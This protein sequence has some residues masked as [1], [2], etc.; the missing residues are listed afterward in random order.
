MAN[1]VVLVIAGEEERYQPSPEFGYVVKLQ[2]DNLMASFLSGEIALLSNMKA[3]RIG[4]R[5]RSRLW[6]IEGGLPFNDNTSGIGTLST[7]GQIQYVAPLFISYSETVA[8][9][10][11]IV[12]KVKANIDIEQ[13]RQV[14]QPLDCVIKKQMEFTTQEYLLDVLGADADAVFY[15]VEEL[16]EIDCVEWAA[17]NIACQGR[18]A[19]DI[20]EQGYASNA[21]QIS[22]ISGFIPNDEYMPMQW[23]LHNTGQFGYTPD[24]DI[25]ALEAWEITAGDPNIVIAI[26]D[27]GVDVNHPDLMDN[28]VQGYDFVDDDDLP[29]PEDNNSGTINNHGTMCAGLAAADG[30]NY[31]GV[32]GVAWNC[33]I[34]PIRIFHTLSS[35]DYIFITN[36]EKATAFRWAADHGA[37]IFSNSWTG[38]N[39]VVQSAI[40]DITKP[41]GIGRDGKGCVVLAA[42]GNDNEASSGRPARFPESIAVGATGDDDLRRNYSNYGPELDIMA[43]SGEEDAMSSGIMSTKIGGSEEAALSTYREG[44]WGTSTATPIAAGVAALILSMEPELTSDEVRYILMYSAK[45]LGEPGED[46]YYGWGRV[47]AR[48]ALEMVL[49]RRCDLNGD[50]RVDEQDMALL[51]EYIANNDLL[52]DIAPAAKRDAVLDDNDIELMMQYMGTVIPEMPAHDPN[53][54]GHWKLDEMEGTVTYG[55]YDIYGERMSAGEV[56]GNALWLPDGGISGGA[57]ELDGIDDYISTTISIEPTEGNFSVFAWIKGGAGGEVIISQ[58]G[59]VNWLMADDADGGLRT[60]LKVPAVTGRGPK[61]AG[62]PLIAA[63]SVTD[64]D[65]HRVAFVRDGIERILYVDDVEVA[66]DTAENLEPASGVLNIGTGATMEAGTY[67]SG[68]I[69][70]VQIYNRAE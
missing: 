10:P 8:V 66:R 2:D 6:I 57:L 65:W 17:P 51:N 49:A 34:M 40:A 14:C 9:I 12:V 25:N 23:H 29:Y 1:E 24:A 52:G 19:N 58:E 13:L 4:G 55:I 50:W 7:G 56:H 63:V 37:D 33:K 42:T 47:D 20:V 11:E 22:P 16:N 54:I 43:P 39:Q 3:R 69:D 53:L 46:D 64:G 41:G 18:P 62:P 70:D 15:A 68:L 27:D 67:W 48:A 38:A 31:I 28:L 36:A 21:P 35:E 60:D 30:D 59:G 44:N 45:D 32:I 26:L 5:S 61:P